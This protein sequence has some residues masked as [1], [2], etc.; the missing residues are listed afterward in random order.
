MPA[1]HL[2]RRWSATVKRQTPPTQQ[3]LAWVRGLLSEPE[4]ALWQQLGLADQT[5]TIAVARHVE[6]TYA[7]DQ[8]DSAA[9]PTQTNTACVAALLHDIGKITA[10]ASATARVAAALLRPVLPTSRTTRWAQRP[11]GWLGGLGRLL[12][13]PTSGAT[14]LATAGSNDQVVAWAAEHHLAPKHWSVDQRL[15]ACLQLADKVAR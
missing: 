7:V 14:L 8:P 13:Y 6:K 5:H 12:N 11:N 15:G 2:V 10:P 1:P 3:D 9:S 4:L